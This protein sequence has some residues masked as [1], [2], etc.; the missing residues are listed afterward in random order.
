MYG[1][2]LGITADV[3]HGAG[4]ITPA[5]GYGPWPSLEAWGADA[6]TRIGTNRTALE[7]TGSQRRSR[8][9]TS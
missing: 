9:G 8:I 7:Q 2:P 5:D 6:R 1:D 3:L 4:H